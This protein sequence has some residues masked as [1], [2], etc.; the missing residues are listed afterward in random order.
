ML[1]WNIRHEKEFAKQKV[2]DTVS[3][4]FFPASLAAASQLFL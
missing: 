1:K 4:G 3:A 2:R